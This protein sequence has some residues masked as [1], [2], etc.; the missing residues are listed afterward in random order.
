[1]KLNKLGKS[2]ILSGLVCSQMYAQSDLDI[3]KKDPSLIWSMP[4]PTEDAQIYVIKTNRPDFCITPIQNI[5]EKAIIECL[6]RDYTNI[7]SLLLLSDGLLSSDGINLSEK[8]QLAVVKKSGYAIQYIKN[9]SEKTQL[10]A[11]KN[12]GG[13]ISYIK[14]PTKK[15]IDLAKSMGY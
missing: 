9:P 10:A 14:N 13:A 6:K 12:Y 5:T 15:V 3:V 1:M 7:D 8:T 11:V 2:I 4:Y